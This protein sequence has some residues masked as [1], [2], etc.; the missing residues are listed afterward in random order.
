MNLRQIPNTLCVFRIVLV[1]PILW[2]ITGGQYEIALL[3]FIVAG[4]T[5]ALD[6][7]LARQFDWHTELGGFLDPIADKLLMV[8]VMVWLALEQLVP[9]WLALILIS[10]DII[11]VSGALAYRL[12]IGPFAG[13]ASGASKVNTAMQLLFVTAILAQAAYTLLPEVV[14]AV[15]GSLV[16]VTAIVSG[17]S[18]IR[19]WTRLALQARNSA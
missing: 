14:I 12:L 11:I 18:Y 19:D 10:R 6:G 8:F 13:S 17:L 2:S 5:D 4:G 1:A 15:M 3:L 16:F 7:F 9:L